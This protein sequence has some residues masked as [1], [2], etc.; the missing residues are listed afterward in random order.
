MA[1]SRKEQLERISNMLRETRRKATPGQA[2][3]FLLPSFMLSPLERTSS[4]F[5]TCDS[6]VP[7][8]I[9]EQYCAEPVS[10]W[11]VRTMHHLKSLVTAVQMFIRFTFA[12][13]TMDLAPEVREIYEKDPRRNEL[14]EKIVSEIDPL[15]QLC[16]PASYCD[17]NVYDFQPSPIDHL[18]TDFGHTF[19]T[20]LAKCMA[21]R[22][23][24]HKMSNDGI[25]TPEAMFFGD[26]DLPTVSFA[27]RTD[28]QGNMN[29]VFLA[30]ESIYGNRACSGDN[31]ND[32][33]EYARNHGIFSATTT[34]NRGRRPPA[35]HVKQHVP[36]NP[37]RPI[38]PDVTAR[39]ATPTPPSTPRDT[40]KNRRRGGH[41]HHRHD[42]PMPPT[43]P[44]PPSAPIPSLVP[45]PPTTP[46][47][48]TKN[49]RRGGHQHR[50][51]GGNVPH[52]YV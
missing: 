4:A 37:P 26:C 39:L 16:M 12:T 44:M 33:F 42:A 3:S 50:R 48:T 29:F 36:A 11:T 28:A 15:V 35:S 34:M 10:G 23:A 25:I 47:D 45:M 52:V 7:F 2:V 9:Q 46:R 40:T 8:Y 51:R 27:I 21:C 18:R 1:T 38:N 32:I 20:T 41:Q 5:V 22:I 14:V 31:V 49:R 6:A 19:F 13:S 17:P 24:I 30:S 43:T